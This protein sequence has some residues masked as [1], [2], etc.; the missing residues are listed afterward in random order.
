[1][2]WAAA[3]MCHTATSAASAEVAGI[4]LPMQEEDWARVAQFAFETRHSPI[5]LAPGQPSPLY[6]CPM[7][8][9]D[10]ARAA[11]LAFEMRHPG[12]LLAVVRQALEQGTQAR[13]G[14]PITCLG[15]RCLLVS[16]LASQRQAHCWSAPTSTTAPPRT[17][18]A[19][20][21]PDSSLRAGGPP[22]PGPAG[23]HLR[24]TASAGRTPAHP[25]LQFQSCILQEGPR[26]LG[27]LVGMCS[28]SVLPGRLHNQ[29]VAAPVSYHTT[30]AGGPPHPG[31]AGGRHERRG[32][33]AV[34]GIHPVGGLLQCC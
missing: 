25:L 29:T 33:E 11:K 24:F 34:P 22:H 2:A 27:R 4:L 8:D 16:A 17:D 14:V 1:M 15:W 13:A 6:L 3:W 28:C 20:A 5:C 21:A 19:V 31:P 7:Q 26:I 18:G 10:W 32:P 9:E 12:R 23:G 30:Y